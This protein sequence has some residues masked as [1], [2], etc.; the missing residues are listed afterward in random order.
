MFFTEKNPTIVNFTTE[1]LTFSENNIRYDLMSNIIHD[2]KPNQGTFRI[3]IRHKGRNEWYEIQDLNVEKIVS[4][5][6][7]V[8]ESYIHFYEKV[9]ENKKNERD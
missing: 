5:S 2:G 8:S 6:V 9:K 3:Q 7:I 4:Q 1:N